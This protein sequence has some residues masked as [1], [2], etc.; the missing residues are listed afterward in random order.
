VRIFSIFDFRFW[1]SLGF[2]IWSLGFVTPASAAVSVSDADG[3]VRRLDE[4]G[5]VTVVIYSNPALQDWTRKAGAS[6]DQFQGRSDFRSVILVDLRK[7]MAD[8]APG[9]TVRRMQKDLDKEAERIRPSYQKNG[10]KNNPRPDVSAVADF[11]GQASRAVGWDEPA[12][13]KRVVVYGKDGK[14]AFR[15]ED[16]ADFSVLR[17]A[18]AAA[19]EGNP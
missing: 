11:K 10:N 17:K 7:S 6:L 13:Q 14:V 9:Y 8:W 2:G 15:S 16:A 18:V 3:V 19:L 1:I 12:N 5:R 4:P